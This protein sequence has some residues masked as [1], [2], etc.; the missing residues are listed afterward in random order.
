MLRSASSRAPAQE[1]AVKL[2]STDEDAHGAAPTSYV[3]PNETGHLGVADDYAGLVPTEVPHEQA[4][5]AV[6][7][8]GCVP[9]CD[10]ILPRSSVSQVFLIFRGVRV[11]PSH[12]GGS[13]ALQ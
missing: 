8:F 11:V 13:P 5:E 2:R 12:P 10:Q 3:P 9:P 4:I 1:P 7:V 6:G